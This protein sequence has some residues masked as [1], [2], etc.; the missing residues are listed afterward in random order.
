MYMDRREL[1]KRSGIVTAGVAIGASLPSGRAAL[2]TAQD[3]GTL[4]FWDTLND[5]VRGGVVESLGD[6]FEGSHAGLAVEHRGWTLDE[7]SATLPRSVDS[8]QGPAVAQVNNGEALAGPMIRGGQLVSLAPYAA[9]YGWLD[10]FAPGLLARNMYSA[11]GKVFGEGDIWGISAE[12]EIVGFYYNKQV[13]TDNGLSVPTT[14]AEFETLL[15]ALRKAGQEPLVFGNLDKWQAIHL[16]GEMQG[17]L[18]TREFLDNLIYRRGGATFDDTS[19]VD[20][21]A[22]ITAWNE[23][24]YFMQGFEGINGD[25][26]TALFAT[27]AGAILLQGSWAAG[28]V[29]EGLGAENAGFFLMPPVE[30]GGT[31]MNVGGVGIPYSITTNA[32]DPALAAEF[33]DHLVSEEAFN[34]F[35]EAGSLPSG[36]IAADKIV[37]NTLSGDLYTNW[38][39]ALG[40]DAVGHYLDW[41]APDFYDTLTGTLQELLGG[42]KNAQEVADTLQQFYAASFA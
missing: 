25:D 42:Q 31:V 32:A 24:G 3:A 6:S 17:T 18:T 30:A 16:Y 20:A 12:S 33:I 8:R 11:D 15:G 14:I 34:L 9:K 7:L 40:A 22:K 5:E 36:E 13:F 10:R 28:T 35:I 27:G 37:A 38:N 29:A 19:F 41:A 23:A 21:A 26:A 4:A 39:V 2:A 1:L